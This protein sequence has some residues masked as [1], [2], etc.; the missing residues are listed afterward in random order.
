MRSAE[1]IWGVIDMIPTTD[2]PDIRNR[3]AIH[4]NNG[5]YMV[6]PREGDLVRLYIQLT[7]ADVL[8]PE[9][10]RLDKDKMGPEQLLQVA[11]RSFHPYKIDTQAFEWW[12]IY[13]SLY[14]LR[15]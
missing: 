13:I 15:V 11:Q 9:T 4:S 12:T 7:D 14:L 2:F 6:I 8:N 1:Y 5:S 3:T 10:G